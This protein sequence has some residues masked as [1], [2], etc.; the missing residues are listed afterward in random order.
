MKGNALSPHLNRDD[1]G[2][3]SLLMGWVGGPLWRCLQVQDM[4]VYVY[5]L[6]G[7]IHSAHVYWTWSYKIQNRNIGNPTNIS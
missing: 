3:K 6:S 5:G 1:I 2:P 4:P 7:A